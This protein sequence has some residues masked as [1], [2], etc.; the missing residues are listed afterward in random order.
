MNSKE[1]IANMIK[2]QPF[3]RLA[4]YEG[5]WDETLVAWM[6]QGYPSKTIVEDERERIVPVDPFHH[7]TYDLHR[8][9]GFFDTE[10]LFGQK[11]IIEET[12]EWEIRLDGAGASLKWWKNKSGTPEHIDFRMNSRAV[13]E[14]EYRPHL[15]QPDRRRF[16]GKWWGDGTL[17]DDRREL[18]LARSRDQWAWVGHVFLWEIMRSSLGDFTMYQ[19]LLLDPGWILDFNRVYTDFLKEHFRILFSE[20]G[21]PDGAWLFDDMAYKSGLFASPKVMNELFLPFY[22]EIVSFFNDEYGLPVLF[23]SDGRIHQA[24]PILLE[25]GF[26]GLHPL[27]NKA[28][29]DPVELAEQFGDRLIF[30]GGFDVRIFETNDRALIASKIESLL[31]EIKAREVGYVFGSDHT[32]TPLVKYDTYRFALDV[33]EQNRY[34]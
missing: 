20:N 16:N 34:L 15:L 9:G 3:D 7:F 13:W 21:V 28:G 26:V 24:I 30:V 23:H 4:L 1:L 11:E 17:S 5:F 19:N 14:Q 6:D 25:A 18:A 32:I 31:Q 2:H 22:A 29:C 8:C 12:D 27:E 10:P 33:F